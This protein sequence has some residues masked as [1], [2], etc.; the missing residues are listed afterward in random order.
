MD[1][2]TGNFNTVLITG[3]LIGYWINVCNLFLSL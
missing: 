3:A 1:E 2:L